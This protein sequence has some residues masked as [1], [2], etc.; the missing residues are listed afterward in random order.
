MLLAFKTDLDDAVVDGLLLGDQE[1]SLDVLHEHDASS[2]A[3]QWRESLSVN[4]VE[5]TPRDS[6]ASAHDLALGRVEGIEGVG[7]E[8]VG[9]RL[10]DGVASA[11]EEAGIDVVVK[12]S[13]HTRVA[14]DKTLVVGRELPVTADTHDLGSGLLVLGEPQGLTL[15][16]A[17]VVENEDGVLFEPRRSLQRREARCT[18]CCQERSLR[19]KNIVPNGE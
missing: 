7:D 12:D 14:G 10:S 8:A 18:C 11:D 6:L 9:R 15:S 5:G 1:S 13:E 19:K 16:E 2:L 17:Q 3:R 4:A